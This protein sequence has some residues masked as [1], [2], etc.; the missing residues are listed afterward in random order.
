MV[1]GNRDVG[2]SAIS[3]SGGTVMLD[4]TASGNGGAV[5]GVVT[6][7]K[8]EP[9]QN[10]VIVAVPEM[11]LR[12]RVDRYRKTVSDQSGRFTLHGV[13]P[14]DYTLLAWDSVEGEAYYNPEFLKTYE[15][16]GSVLRMKEGDRKTAQVEVVPDSGEQP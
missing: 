6:D 1:A 9:V 8:G 4:L 7:Q 10:A 12:T 13:P 3:V 11:R 5:D 2:D 14:G 16:Q 15:G